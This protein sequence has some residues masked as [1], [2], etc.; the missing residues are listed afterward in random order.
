MARVKRAVHARKK[1]NAYLKA[2]K[3]Y[4]GG[5][6]RLWRTVKDAVERSQEYSYIGR[7]HKKRNFR[8][9]WIVRVNAAVRAHGLSYSQFI[10]KLKQTGIELDRKALAYLA[11]EEPDTFN[12]IVEKCKTID[13]A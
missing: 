9:L 5:R 7:K 13:V 2:A 10:H 3:G 8:R 11:V 6:S 4:R 1:K 12:S